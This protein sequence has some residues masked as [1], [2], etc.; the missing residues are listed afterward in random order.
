[1]QLQSG[2]LPAKL[3]VGEI[4][5]EY[6]SFYRDPADV[7]E[8]PDGLALSCLLAIGGLFAPG[9]LIAALAP[10]ANS[11]NAIGRLA[12]IPLLFFACLAR[13]YVRQARTACTSSPARLSFMSCR[14]WLTT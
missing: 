6:R 4:L 11:V 1:V 8:S 5:E 14:M 10:T 7:D 12:L 13:R 3:R 9:L 2:A